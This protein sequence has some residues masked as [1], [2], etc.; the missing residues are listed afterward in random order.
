MKSRLEEIARAL[1]ADGRGILAA[2]ESTG[3]IARRLASVGV[4]NVEETR[5]AY[6]ELLFTA[7]GIGEAISGVILY[8][9]TIR[10]ST[11]KGRR[12][13]DVLTEQGVLAGIKVDRGAKPLPGFPGE[14]VTEGLDGLWERLAEYRDLGASFAKW[15]AVIDVG[16]RI[17]S[18]TA[19][20]ANAEALA[21]YAALC[22]EAGI[23]P[24][25]E[26]EVL[27]D[28][29]HDL[30]RCEE[31]TARTLD[32]VFS[33]LFAHHVALEGMVLKPNMVIPGLRH[34]RR[35]DPDEV[36]DATVRCFRRT[37]PA[38]VPGVVFLS[39]GQREAEATANLQAMNARHRD[40]VPWSLS[41]S[42]GRAL[43]QSTLEAWRGR[44]DNVPAAQKALLHRARLN[45]AAQRGRYDPAMEA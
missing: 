37:V 7:K 1:V 13:V 44:S 9:E 11:R 31:V 36:A 20:R 22:Q 30:A 3:T 6:R 39:G 2:D 26:P 8:D 33:A 42:F 45:G 10:Q 5:R 35:A 25:V 41:F 27:M 28:G 24:I 12:F 4:E 18:A 32:A 23:V 19:I 40:A 15:R 34:G 21:R 16:P 38:A 14:R 17:P 43:Q 29:D